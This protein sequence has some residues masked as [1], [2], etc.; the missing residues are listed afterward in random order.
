MLR[1]DNNEFLLSFIFPIDITPKSKDN[2]T[3]LAEATQF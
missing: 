1:S 2:V 3:Q